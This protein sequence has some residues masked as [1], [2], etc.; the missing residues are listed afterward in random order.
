MLW[1]C[2]RKKII[3]QSD[4]LCCQVCYD[5]SGQCAFQ[6]VNVT[7]DVDECCG[8]VAYNPEREICCFG[9]KFNN[10]SKN[11]E[12]CYEKMYN[13]LCCSENVFNKTSNNTECCGK[14]NVFDSSANSSELCC[15][16][17]KDEP[18]IVVQKPFPEAQCC[19][20]PSSSWH[21]S[22]PGG[23]GGFYDPRTQDCCVG[24]PY[25]VSTQGCCNNGLVAHFEVFNITSHTC[26]TDRLSNFF[27]GRKAFLW[28]KML[29]GHFLRHKYT[30]ML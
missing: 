6:G 27:C 3:I 29:L 16:F 19:S 2:P 12:C 5:T 22:D 7:S 15:S 1:R 28:C 25:N 30:W 26:C 11:A 20:V 9:Y 23:D 10:P 24:Q 17:G 14:N 13:Q 21:A 4:Q 18:L 8:S